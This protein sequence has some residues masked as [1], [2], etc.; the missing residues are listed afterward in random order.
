M[1]PGING[2]ITHRESEAPGQFTLCT[3]RHEVQK[4][5]AELLL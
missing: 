4:I 5:N 1:T 3:E 2:T